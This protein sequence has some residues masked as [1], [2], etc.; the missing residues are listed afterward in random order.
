[1]SRVL[2][3]THRWVVGV[4]GERAAWGVGREHTG[5]RWVGALGA[6]TELAVREGE[7]PSSAGKDTAGKAPGGWLGT[8]VAGNL[9]QADAGRGMRP[10]IQA[11]THDP[12]S[13]SRQD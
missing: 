7:A 9:G 3:S 5:A 11:G 1:M 12:R 10:T 8:G 4:S 13:A 6:A 2:D